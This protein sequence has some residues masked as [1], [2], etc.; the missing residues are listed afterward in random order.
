MGEKT[1][2]DED[3]REYGAEEDI[4]AQEGLGNRGGEKNT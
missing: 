2:T 1:W 4:L 3:V